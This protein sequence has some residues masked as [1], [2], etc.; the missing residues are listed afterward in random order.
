VPN[1][2]SCG[3]GPVQEGQQHAADQGEGL[4][5]DCRV[6]IQ[7][8]STG[9]AQAY[10]DQRTEMPNQSRSGPKK[11]HADPQGR[12]GPNLF[13]ADI[14]RRWLLN[15]DSPIDGERKPRTAETK[16][17]DHG[18]VEKSRHHSHKRA[19]QEIG[20]AESVRMLGGKIFPGGTARSEGK[21]PP[22]YL[23]R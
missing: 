8:I 18:N 21:S 22:P 16:M 15:D 5:T 11:R 1:I 19:C 3:F 6:H 13:H 10:L 14:A 17:I 23:Q 20:F 7:E 2:A 9:H 12:Y 4:D